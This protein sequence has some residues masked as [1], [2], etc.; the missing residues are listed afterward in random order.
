MPN[1]ITTGRPSDVHILQ[2]GK[3]QWR[4]RRHDQWKKMQIHRF[5]FPK[6]NPVQ[7]GLRWS[8]MAMTN[9]V[10]VYQGSCYHYDG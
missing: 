3:S 5:L 7:R 4:A 6:K 1:G 8:F 2:E 9:D 10:Y